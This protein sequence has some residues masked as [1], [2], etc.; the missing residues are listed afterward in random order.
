MAKEDPAMALYRDFANDIYSELGY[1]A[2]W[3]PGTKV[4]LG[5]V[6][7]IE[8][9]VLKVETTLSSLATPFETDTDAVPEGSLDYQSKSGVSVVLKAAGSLDGRFKALTSADAGALVEFSND[10]AILMQLKNVTS[11]RIANQANLRR[12][13]L[14]AVVA[15]DDQKR[16]QRDWVVVTD[17]V[18][19]GSATIVIS[20]GSSSRLELKASASVAPASLAD[21]TARLTTVIADQ[22]STKI[23]AESGLTPLYRALRVKRNFWWLYDEVV[24]A[25]GEAPDP[26]E[27]FDDADPA[28][29]V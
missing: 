23:V 9:G 3:L 6:G 19:A 22:V 11:Q 10:K 7:R 2:T 21:A 27:L 20:G 13:L 29:D 5:D 25:S 12:A 16:W 4:R 24:T 28:V 14:S 26:E 8:N 17:V 15:A 18:N 1:R